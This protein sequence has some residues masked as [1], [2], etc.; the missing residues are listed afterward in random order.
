MAKQ[1]RFTDPD[2]GDEMDPN[3]VPENVQDAA[4]QFVTLNRKAEAASEKANDAKKAALAL[5][6]ENDVAR[7]RVDNGKKWFVRTN[8]T[9]G[10]LEAVKKSDIKPADDE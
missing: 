6:E 3:P 8:K 4:D 2:T 7:V 9:G 5:M 1:R 10:K